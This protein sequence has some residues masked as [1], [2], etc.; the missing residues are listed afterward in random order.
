M[1]NTF[2]R[3]LSQSVGTSPATIGAYTVGAATQVTVIGMSVAN[4]SASAV[5]ADIVHNNGSTDTFLIKAGPIPVGSSLVLFGG[6]QKL[7]LV[8]GDSV[9]VTSSAAASL[10]VVMSILE[11]T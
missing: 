5:T 9:K 10:D 2:A 1:A 7:V 3:K 11:I 4:T 8:T 6:D